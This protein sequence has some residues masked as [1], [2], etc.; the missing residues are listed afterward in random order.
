MHVCRAAT[1]LRR[2]FSRV[3]RPQEDELGTLLRPYE[4]AG[5][6]ATWRPLVSEATMTDA[7]S[8]RS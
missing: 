7:S 2:T 3:G 8:C 1:L 4:L 5:S 6:N